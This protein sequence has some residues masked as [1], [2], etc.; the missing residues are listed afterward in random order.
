MAQIFAKNYLLRHA[1]RPNVTG[2]CQSPAVGGGIP[3][4][5]KAMGTGEH[6]QHG[7]IKTGLGFHSES[8]SW[9]KCWPKT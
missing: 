6:L 8:Y 9:A 4:A 1:S 7:E 3:C 5:Q 2:T